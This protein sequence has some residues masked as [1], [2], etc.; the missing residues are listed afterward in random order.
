MKEKSIWYYQKNYICSISDTTVYFISI[1]E[2][3][4]LAYYDTITGVIYFN[5][6][7]EGQFRKARRQIL[8]DFKPEVISSYTE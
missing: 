5:S 6:L 3:V 1:R 7:Y 2:H 4:D 8:K